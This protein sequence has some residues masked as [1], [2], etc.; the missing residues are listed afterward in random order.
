MSPGPKL[1]C[2]V[3]LVYFDE[4]VLLCRVGGYG[5]LELVLVV[6]RV[7][8]VIIIRLRLSIP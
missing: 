5:T 2:Y 3:V 4:L 1:E 8:K 6:G 7:A